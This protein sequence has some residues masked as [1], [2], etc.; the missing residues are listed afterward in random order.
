MHF[1]NDQ[2]DGFAFTANGM[3]VMDEFLWRGVTCPAGKLHLSSAKVGDLIDYLASW[4]DGGRVYLD[5]FIYD[6]FG[7]DAPVDAATR[8]Q[9]LA[10]VDRFNGKFLPQPYTQLARVLSAAGHDRD[11]RKVLIAREVGLGKQARDDR[12]VPRNGQVW[13]DF[14][15]PL[16]GIRNLCS[17]VWDLILRGV[18]GYGYAPGR[19]VIALI[20]LIGIA[21]FLADQTWV[22]GSFA[23]NSDYV[24][25]S[26]SWTDLTALDCFGPMP[27]PLPPGVTEC[28]PNPAA[29]WSSKAAPGMD[30]ESFSARAYAADLVIPVLDLGQTSAWA[31]SSSRGNWGYVLWWARWVLASLGWLVTALGAAAVTGI[32]QKDRG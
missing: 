19:S 18:A 30:W 16:A 7:F 9:W 15:R 28:T 12:R 17:L 32:I 29:I 6:R 10:R 8:L 26:P 2:P 27:N 22:E 11:A 31:P 4:P 3:K 5:G 14:V 25:L 13:N 23:P 20:G 24:I 1:Q 21:W